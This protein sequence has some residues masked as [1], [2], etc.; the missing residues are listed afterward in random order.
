MANLGYEL[1]INELKYEQKSNVIPLGR[2]RIGTFYHRALLY[3]VLADRINLKV[4][5]TRG[6]Y[7]RAC[8]VVALKDENSVSK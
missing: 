7:N 2:I 1:P 4:S 5:L 6:D 3:K 8:N